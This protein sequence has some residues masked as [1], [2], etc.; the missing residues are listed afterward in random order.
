M[1][2]IIS[3]TKQMQSVATDFI[4]LTTPHFKQQAEQIFKHLQS[5]SVPALANL[6]RCNSQLVQL[7]YERLHTT[8]ISH[9]AA[10]M[11]YQGLQFQNLAA[12]V[13]DQGSLDYLQEH[14]YI[15][16]ALYGLLRPFDGIIPYR[17]EMQS[18]L[19]IDTSNSMYSF[20]ADNLANTIKKRHPAEPILN[21][22]SAEYTKSLQPYL[23]A[24]DQLVTVVFAIYRNGKYLQQA[25]IAKQAR[26]LMVRMLAQ[27]QSNS[28]DDV[29]KFNDMGFM[30]NATM[31]TPT[32]LVFTRD[33]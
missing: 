31:S 6:W 2:I 33:A 5:M 17:L 19:S 24:T 30:Y 15:V 7:N 13:L 14:L 20:W 27:H 9:T 16:S 32:K 11:S 23:K 10:I 8:K 1:Q 28:L 18:K 4:T 26:G 21:L 25:T 22:A 29:K 3:P 12:N